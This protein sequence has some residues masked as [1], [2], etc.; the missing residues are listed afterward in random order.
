MAEID[1]SKYNTVDQIVEDIKSVKI[2]GAT[3]VAI[4]TFEGMKLFLRTY[5]I[6]G[7]NFHDFM[8]ELNR[9]GYI[10]AFARPNEPLA[11]NG[12]KFVMRML[13]SRNPGLNDVEKAKVKVNE[14]CDEFL[15]LIAGAKGKIVENSESVMSNVN[16][17]L[18]HCHSSTAVR[19]IINQSKR[20]D[21]FKAVCTETRPLFQ[22]RKTAAKLHEAGIDT[23]FIVDSAAEAFIIDK[24][25]HPI[26]VVFLGA[27]EI[28]MRG[29][30][31]NKIGS[32]GIALAS[33]FASKP[34]YIVTSI[35]KV[36]VETAYRPVKIEYRE[37]KEIWPG[38]PKNL[39]MVN[40][41]FEIINREFIAGFITEAGVIKPEDIHKV[42]SEK[43]RWLF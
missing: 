32:W 1:F 15:G 16:E 8:E 26:D 14:L 22:G 38:A 18:T 33:Y 20:I 4:S 27:D 23:T 11:K 3:N 31:I 40:P 25:T 9:V 34:V 12:L 21:N 5:N 41:A 17:V 35:L 10:L 29:D 24:G 28:T 2:Q 6:R 37:S 36:E 7:G 42:I 19:I 13:E 30:A 43:Y 39:K